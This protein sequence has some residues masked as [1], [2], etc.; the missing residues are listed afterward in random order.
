MSCGLGSF[1]TNALCGTLYFV[2]NTSQDRY[3]FIPCTTFETNRLR[4]NNAAWVDLPGYRNSV[5]KNVCLSDDS[6][7]NQYKDLAWENSYQDFHS[8][9]QSTEYNYQNPL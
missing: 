9:I 4:E 7:T 2:F 6:G 3:V 8:L 1:S 5:F